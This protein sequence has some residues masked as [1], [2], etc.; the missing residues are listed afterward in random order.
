MQNTSV[1]LT[2]SLLSEATVP[3]DE[4]ADAPESTL[5]EMSLGD[6]AT[7]FI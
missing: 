1:F 7:W 6:D 3:A 5:A 2:F 4:V